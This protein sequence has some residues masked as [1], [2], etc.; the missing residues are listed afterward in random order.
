[1]SYREISA[2]VFN[3]QDNKGPRTFSKFLIRLADLAPRV[4]LKQ[5]SL[6]RVHLDSESYP[7]RIALIEIVGVLVHEIAMESEEGA[8]DEAG[9]T[10]QEGA[11]RREK[12][13][14]KLF[15]LLL[16]RFCDVSSYVR[17]KV[18]QT[19][20]KLLEYVR[21]RPSSRFFTYG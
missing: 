1:M 3:G 12:K 19:V 17:I 15:D 11:E 10:A 18:L 21:D 5:F 7:M 4:I 6:L 14:S 16:E 2:Q 13:I 20:S 8:D 9:R